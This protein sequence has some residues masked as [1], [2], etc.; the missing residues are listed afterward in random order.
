M[1][2]SSINKDDSIVMENGLLL[3]DKSESKYEHEQDETNNSNVL[4]LF[5]NVY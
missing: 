3:F 5:F 4:I 1:K 2:E